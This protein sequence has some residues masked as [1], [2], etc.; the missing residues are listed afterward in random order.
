MI[1]SAI[2]VVIV[3]FSVIWRRIRSAGLCTQLL[4]KHISQSCITFTLIHPS[5]I[6]HL[7]RNDVGRKKKNVICVSICGGWHKTRREPFLSLTFTFLHLFLCELFFFLLL[8]NWQTKCWWGSVQVGVN[9]A[10][11]HASPIVPYAAYTVYSTYNLPQMGNVCCNVSI[12]CQNAK[13]SAVVS[14]LSSG[15]NTFVYVY[16]HIYQEGGA[17]QM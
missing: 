2:Q 5:Y 9:C 11:S 10:L 7:F 15:P 8:V 16:T 12:L 4:I 6:F 1:S 17:P 3:F 13:V 14:S